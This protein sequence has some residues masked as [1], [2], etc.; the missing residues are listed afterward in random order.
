ML[1]RL[2]HAITITQQPTKENPSRDKILYF[3][4][5]TEVTVEK[6]FDNFTQLATVKLPRNLRYQDQNLYAGE[7]PLILR[8][9]KIKIEFG[10][11][12]NL[13]IEFEGY[14]SKVN[15][16][17]PI[18]IKCEDKMWILKQKIVSK[19]SYKEVTL[20]TLLKQ[21]IGDTVP[22]T[23]IDADLG[24]IRITEA[25]VGVVLN[26]LRSEYGLYSFF[27]N[28]ILRCGLPYYPDE[29]TEHTFL[30]EKAIIQSESDL[31]YL[32]SEDVKIKIKGVLIGD[33]NVK[34]EIEVGDTT[35]DLRTV[36]QYGGTVAQLTRLCNNYLSDYNF[37]GYY[38]SFTTFLEP[39]VSV[40]DYA[41]INSY[42]MPERN[43][44]YLIKSVEKSSGVN[45]GRQKIELE[46]RIV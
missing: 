25:S 8:G 39:S 1:L 2:R 21:I 30:F 34:T 32:R 24:K 33:D 42:M 9:D 22:Y 6:S 27:K 29:A 43:G 18:E 26:K 14:I 36:Y 28:G 41:T 31:E 23:Y 45:G 16:N 15:N 10:Y 37:T 3:P 11:F 44:T 13:T 12:P 40:G 35:G 7:N 46:R 4:F 17:I 20:K 38:G 19:L 5:L